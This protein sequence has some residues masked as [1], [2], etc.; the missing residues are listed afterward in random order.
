LSVK[1]WEYVLKGCGEEI[2]GIS[3]FSRININFEKIF[4]KVSLNRNDS[5]LLSVE[6]KNFDNNTQNIFLFIS[7]FDPEVKKLNNLNFKVKIRM[8]R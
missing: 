1:P 3:N 5:C 8:I 6:I 7:I 4:N 2:R